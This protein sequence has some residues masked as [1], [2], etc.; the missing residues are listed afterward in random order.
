VKDLFTQTRK[1][2]KED[3]KIFFASF[4]LFGKI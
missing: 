3:Q 2:R 1:T 4:A